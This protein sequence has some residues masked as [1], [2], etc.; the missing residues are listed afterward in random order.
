VTT[1]IDEEP[2]VLNEVSPLMG[3]TVYIVA[4]FPR[5]GFVEEKVKIT[6]AEVGYPLAYYKTDRWIRVYL[7]GEFNNVIEAMEVFD[8]AWPIQ[9]GN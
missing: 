1:L 5:Q 2:I 9:Y 8:D 6:Q 4:S 3:K 7:D